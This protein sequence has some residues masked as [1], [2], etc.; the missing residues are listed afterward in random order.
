MGFWLVEQGIAPSSKKGATGGHTS[1]PRRSHYLYIETL[2]SGQPA[3]VLDYHG[4]RCAAF[5]HRGEGQYISSHIPGHLYNS[6][7]R[8]CRNDAEVIPIGVLEVFEYVVQH[9]VLRQSENMRLN[10]PIGLGL[11]ISV[12]RNGN[13]RIDGPESAAIEIRPKSYSNAIDDS[14]KIDAFLRAGC[15]GIPKTLVHAQ[16]ISAPDLNR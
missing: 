3:R 8:C 14:Y 15:I 16:S 5:R 10:D 9:S 11:P 2:S 4:D 13:D 7:I 1:A 6:E 12:Q